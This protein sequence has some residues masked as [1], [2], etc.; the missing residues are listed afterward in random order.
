MVNIPRGR[1]CVPSPLDQAAQLHVEFLNRGLNMTVHCIPA[2]GPDYAPFVA[3][4][5]GYTCEQ[6]A[7]SY[8]EA[9]AWLDRY[10]AGQ[11]VIS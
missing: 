4:T 11:A 9:I 7:L 1:K 3:V 6:I 2:C 10:D 8:D 5:D